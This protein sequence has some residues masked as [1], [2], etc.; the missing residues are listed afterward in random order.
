MMELLVATG[1][2][3]KFREI[4]ELL[5]DTVTKLYSLDDFPGNPPG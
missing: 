1:N 4:E 2:R 5:R 3:G